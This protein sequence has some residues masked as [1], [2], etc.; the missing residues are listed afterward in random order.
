[1]TCILLVPQVCVNDPAKSEIKKSIIPEYM[2]SRSEFLIQ[3]T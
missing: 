2:E 3:G 1:M